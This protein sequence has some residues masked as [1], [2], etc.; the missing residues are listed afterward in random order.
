MRSLFA[1]LWRWAAEL[2]LTV[3]LMEKSWQAKELLFATDF[4]I[5]A[6]VSAFIYTGVVGVF[7]VNAN[8]WLWALLGAPV[9]GILFFVLLLVW[10]RYF[11]S[12]RPFDPRSWAGHPI[13]SV[14]MAACL[15]AEIRPWPAIPAESPAYLPLQKIKAAIEAKQIAMV[16]GNGNMQSRV[17]REEL[18]KLANIHSERPR[19]LFG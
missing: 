1:R 11:S 10:Q 13:Y 4:G 14:W 7:A 19:F 15:W 3:W 6:A 18:I 16:S 8:S 17:T 12:S 9:A 5:W 2:H